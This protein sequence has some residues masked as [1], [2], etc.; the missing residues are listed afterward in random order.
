MA[1]VGKGQRI[2][3]METELD[4]P[5]LETWIWPS[6]ALG[7]GRVYFALCGDEVPVLLVKRP[8]ASLAEHQGSLCAVFEHDLVLL[9]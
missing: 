7:D 3:G 2:A 5:E 9:E 4:N 6:R 8:C 1:D